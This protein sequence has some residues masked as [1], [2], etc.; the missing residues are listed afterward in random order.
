MQ[1]ATDW[2]KFFCIY[3]LKSY[4]WIGLGR[5][6]D[7]NIW[8]HLFY[9]HRSTVLITGIHTWSFMGTFQ[10]IQIAGWYYVIGLHKYK[11]MKGSLGFLLCI[12][13]Y[14]SLHTPTQTFKLQKAIPFEGNQCNV[15]DD[16][17]R[18][19]GWIFGKTPMGSFPIQFYFADCLYSQWP[20]WSS[21]WSYWIIFG[22]IWSYLIMTLII[23]CDHN[24]W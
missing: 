16:R 18:I 22:H 13:I 17:I 6:W 11:C 5:I 7:G 4:K 9:E 1:T 3:R 23:N 24:L 15:R 20:F 19:F 10:Q 14:V 12:C 8:K 21:I 2:H